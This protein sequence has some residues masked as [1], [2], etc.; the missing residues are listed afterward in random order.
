MNGFK[1]TSEVKLTLCRHNRTWSERWQNWLFHAIPPW[2]GEGL[3]LTPDIR[4]TYEKWLPMDEFTASLRSIGRALL[5]DGWLPYPLR[6]ICYISLPD[7]WAAMPSFMHK[8]TFTAEELMPLFCAMADPPRFG[9]I[10]GRYKSQTNAMLQASSGRH[11]VSILDLGCGVGTNT[12]E[13]V[14]ELEKKVHVSNARGITSEPLEVWMAQNRC[15]PHDLTR[16]AQFR[17]I[18]P[19]THIVFQIGN[20]EDFSGNADFITCNG[21]IGG[22]FFNDVSQYESFLHSCIQT[23]NPGGLVFIANKFHEGCKFDTLRF[24]NQAR[25]HGFKAIGELDWHDLILSFP[26]K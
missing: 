17:T 1:I 15:L 16:E 23:L 26:S 8:V 25:K 24:I 12:C 9:T 4:A 18:S 7:L 3:I 10:A 19:K 14:S 6:Q 22:R 13:I 20:A 2:W 5:P 11:N 21:L